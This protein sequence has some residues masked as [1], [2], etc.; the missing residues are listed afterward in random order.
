METLSDK[1]I[2]DFTKNKEAF[3]LEELQPYFEEGK[4]I[5][6]VKLRMSEIEDFKIL[7]NEKFKQFIDEMCEEIEGDGLEWDQVVQMLKLA[8]EKLI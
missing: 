5:Q 6:K 3:I 4:V 8:G 7:A 2:E 1:I